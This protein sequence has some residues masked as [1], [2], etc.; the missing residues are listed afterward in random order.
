MRHVEKLHSQFRVALLLGFDMKDFPPNLRVELEMERG[1][2]FLVLA[3]ELVDA[4]LAALAVPP[5]AQPAGLWLRT[6]MKK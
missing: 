6:R 5:A 2:H 1:P 3:R 4:L